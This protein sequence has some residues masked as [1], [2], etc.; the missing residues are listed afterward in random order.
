MSNNKLHNDNEL[1]QYFIV[2]KDLNMSTGKIA[3][4]VAHVATI[5]A[6]EQDDSKMDNSFVKFINWYKDNQK[7][8]VLQAHQKDLEK[9]V[10]KG[11]YYIRDNGL[12]EIQPDSL[13]CVSLGILTRAEAKPY[14]KRLQ[15]LK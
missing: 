14:V 5:V 2:N 6:M 9:L 7:K 3:A 8:V 10:E 13:T 1:V 12:T 4:Q 11:F 15:L